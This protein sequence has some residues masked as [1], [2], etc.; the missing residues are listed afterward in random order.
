MTERQM[1]WCGRSLGPEAG[2]C[3]EPLGSFQG[4]TESGSG[5]KG[6]GR[7][8]P[9]PEELFGKQSLQVFWWKMGSV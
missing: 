2:G 6:R 1:A 3:R 4:E 7:G 5:V 8:E 9:G